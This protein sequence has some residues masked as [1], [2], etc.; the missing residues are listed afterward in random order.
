MKDIK[1]FEDLLN[2]KIEYSLKD[3]KIIS[4]ILFNYLINNKIS[5][6]IYGEIGSGKTTL[7]NSLISN[8]N[9]ELNVKSPTYTYLQEYNIDDYKIFHF[10]LYRLK[11]IDDCKAFGFDEYFIDPFNIS[12]IEWPEIVENFYEINKILHLK[13]Y[14]NHFNNK[15][16]EI[17][18]KKITN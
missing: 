18:I 6:L 14:L 7:I 9:K 16:R 12:I 4:E 2:V 10:D 5:I 13:I 15:K 3:L 8:I 17:F 11:N 1:K